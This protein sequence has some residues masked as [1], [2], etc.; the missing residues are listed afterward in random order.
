VIVLFWLGLLTLLVVVLALDLGVFHRAARAQTVSE[1]LL[2]SLAWIGTALAFNVVVYFAYQ[3]HWLGIG[4]EVGHQ[5]DGRPAA[6]QFL[7]A[8]LV[9]KSLSLDN[10]FVIAMIF[11]YFAIPLASQHRVLF[12]GVLGA[13]V[14]RALFIVSGLALVERFAWVTYVFGLLLLATAVKMLVERHDNLQPERNALVRLLAKR[15]AVTEEL[16]GEAFFT[17]R[18]DGWA[19]TPLLLALLVIE[20]SDLL[21]AVDSIP[22]VIAVTRDPFLAFSSNAFAILGMRSLYFVIAPIL[23]RFR[24]LKLSLIFLLAFI[25]VKMLLVHHHQIPTGV[26]LTFIFGILGVGI[27]ASLVAYRRDTVVVP[28]PVEDDLDRLVRVS[29]QTARRLS[30]AVIGTSVLAVG[31]AMI[32]LPGPALVVIPLGLVILSTEF[33]WARR[34]LKRLSGIAPRYGSSK[35]LRR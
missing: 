23:G 2:W 31:I 21:F 19:A 1:A 3:D 34:W 33:I 14:M 26:S 17:R 24:F 27:A 16:H 6:L 32:V 9:E 13:L 5:L 30:I 20:T 18:R 8:Y 22:A 10:I 11:T 12:W 28:S 29:L 7:S 15:L 4:L 35:A 25:G